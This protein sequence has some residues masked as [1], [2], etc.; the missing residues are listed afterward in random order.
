MQQHQK[1][2]LSSRVAIPL[3][4]SQSVIK[5]GL[6]GTVSEFS[7][8]T[9]IT[10]FTGVTVNS[11][12]N[13]LPTV[14]AIT[15]PVSNLNDFEAYEGMYVTFP[16]ALVIAEYFNFDRF[17]EIVLAQPVAGQS[18]PFQPTAVFEPGSPDAINLA[19]LNARSR[20]TLDDG[21]TASNPDPA[22]HPNGNVFDL[23]NT[24]RGGDLVQDATGVLNYAFDLYRIQPTTGANYTAINPRTAAPN[25][26]GDLKVASFNVLNYFT[27]L[28]DSGAICGPAGDQDCRGADNAE[29]LDRQRT[30]IIA[31]LAEIN[32][33]IVGLIEIENHPTNAALADLVAGLNDAVGAGTYDYIA[34]G[35]VGSDAITV[36]FIY[37]PATVTPLGSHAILDDA[38]FVDPLNTGEDRNRPAL[39]QTF[40]ELSDG[41]TVTVV[42]NHFKSKSGSEL[43]D[44]GAICVDGDPGN[45]VPDCD[46]G[47]GQGY[48]NATRT[49]TAQVLAD[50]L[51]T[52]PTGSGDGDIL[53]IGD[54]NA[55]DKENPI[56]ALLAGADDTPSTGDDYNDLLAQF[57]GEY[58]HT[59][60][61]SGQ[62][63]YLDYG[64]ANDSALVQV[65]GAAAW[66]INA[67]EPD[68]LD[69]DTSFKKDAQDAL[70]EP[71]AYRAS[72]HDPVIIGLNLSPYALNGD[73]CIVIALEG[74]PFDGFATVV[75]AKN[76]RFNAISWKHK[77]GL[78]IDTCFE[79]H[80]TN[81]N[82]R[83][84]GA[85]GD[86]TIFGYDGNDKLYGKDGNDMIFGGEGHDYLNGNGGFHDKLYGE[87]GND[88]LVDHDGIAAAHGGAGDDHIRVSLWSIWTSPSGNPEVDGLITGGY[89]NDNVRLII[90]DYSQEYYVNI[91]GDEYDDPPVPAEGQND[92]LILRG[93]I[94][95]DSDIIKF[96]RT[97]LR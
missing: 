9:Q 13:P 28:D 5:L 20:I 71:N 70:Y 90:N 93:R 32:A 62:F 25:V 91:S 81:D 21:R 6:K 64:V 18:F 42:V 22:I 45:D 87:N 89:D 67:D 8:M 54:L 48:F 30:K 96:E 59:Y 60:V 61:F 72:D 43:D 38:S 4:T 94:T 50:W 88:T 15:L 56:S 39:A 63:G 97:H 31:A 68:I 55:Y 1:A 65:T 34:T 11:S 23:T 33:D 74:S 80:G 84:Y 44:S 46:Q 51:A 37:K 40:V 17:N 86:D 36:A 53:I 76:G 58:A 78:P 79:I 83:I 7:D 2:S 12:G 16:Q 95:T 10:S 73:G 82:D 47:D 35:P 19:D 57:V 69:Y 27:T 41:G 26:G 49:A 3:L 52:D 77:Q 29:E 14:T 92:K 75:E 66:N 24:F 85:Y